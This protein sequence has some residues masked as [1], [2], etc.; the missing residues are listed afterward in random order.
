M[1]FCRYG[2][3]KDHNACSCQV[4]YTTSLSCYDCFRHWGYWLGNVM[5][6]VLSIHLRPVVSSVTGEQLDTCLYS[7]IDTRDNVVVK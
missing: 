7:R 6:N 3:I 1:V 2:Q 5:Y 4:V